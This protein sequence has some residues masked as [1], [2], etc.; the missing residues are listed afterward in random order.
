MTDTSSLPILLLSSQ[1]Y[2][3]GTLM[4][5]TP[6]NH[7]EQSQWDE[8]SQVEGRCQDVDEEAETQTQLLTLL[9]ASASSSY[10]SRWM[11]PN[12]SRGLSSTLPSHAGI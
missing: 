9:P 5:W 4:P 10:P 12:L 6:L 7:V 1:C 3:D 11:N 8:I 2:G